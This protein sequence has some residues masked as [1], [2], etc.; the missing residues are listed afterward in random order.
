M[1]TTI[2]LSQVLATLEKRASLDGSE[3]IILSVGAENKYAKPDDLRTYVLANVQ[4]KLDKI[5]ADDMHVR[6]L[7]TV[8]AYD[9]GA[10][11]LKALDLSDLSNQGYWYFS[12][13]G[14]RIL[15]QL[16][17]KFM[18]SR[19]VATIY[20]GVRAGADGTLT[21]DGAYHILTTY[22]QDGTWAAWTEYFDATKITALETRAT[23]LETRA[24]AVEAKATANATAI[25]TNAAD[26]QTNA[27]G[28][29][30]LKASVE[31]V[32]QT[33]AATQSAVST[34]ETRITALE[35]VSGTQGDAIASLQTS[36]NS[37]EN[38]TAATDSRTQG[39]SATDLPTRY[40]GAVQ[41]YDAGAALLKAL[42]LSDLSNQG[43]WYFSMNGVRILCQLEI[44]F[45]GSRAVATIYG[46]VRAGADGTL[47]QDGAYHILT[48]YYQDGTWAAWTEYFDATKITALETRATSLETRATAVEAKATGIQT[49][50]ESIEALQE[51]AHTAEEF[52]RR[53]KPTG[54]EVSCIKRI[55]V[56]NTQPVYINAV[57]TPTDALQN[58]I[59]ISD[60]RACFVTAD[61]RIRVLS[62]GVSTIQVIPTCNT[63]LAKTISIEVGKP[64]A[65]L[66]TLQ[67][68]RLSSDKAFRLT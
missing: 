67:S 11:L 68:L 18:G 41:A 38:R 56:S 24:T 33:A 53:L 36:V 65:R 7:G 39:V 63:A 16:E 17:I 58:I 35:T 28:I 49:N 34:H 15:C 62:E 45:M 60:N 66:N 22:Y 6:Y 51:K 57:L 21:Q 14:V 47:T 43:Y 48:T 61:G 1:S 64:F 40:L 2:K 54:L 13:N 30:T 10:A 3:H 46:G 20:G 25:D 8:Q 9:A 19:A 44:K 55:T 52:Q 26:I 37:V 32:T 59:Y 50:A 4:K 12:M 27:N 23:S 31:T 29:S 5:G 42:D